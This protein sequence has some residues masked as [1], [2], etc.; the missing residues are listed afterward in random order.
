MG[1]LSFNKVKVYHK[2]YFLIL[3]L[4]NEIIK[5]SLL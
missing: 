3:K 5:C 2:N 4:H 1:K